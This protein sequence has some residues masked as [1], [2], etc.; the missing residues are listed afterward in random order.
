MDGNDWMQKEAKLIIAE[1]FIKVSCASGEE[2]LANIHVQGQAHAC[3][4][5]TGDVSLYLSHLAVL[6]PRATGNSVGIHISRTRP[7]G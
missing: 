1:G 7:G 2:S 3:Q 6:P 5:S 4:V